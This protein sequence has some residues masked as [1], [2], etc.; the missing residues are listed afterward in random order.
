MLYFFFFFFFQAEDGI[1]DHCV[2]GVQTCALPI[3][4]AFSPAFRLVRS[5]LL[6]TPGSVPLKEMLIAPGAPFTMVTCSGSPSFKV[7]DCLSS[8]TCL[9]R[10]SGEV[11]IVG[12]AGGTAFPPAFPA[13]ILP[14]GV[15]RK[16]SGSTYQYH[17]PSTTFQVLP[18]GIFMGLSLKPGNI[19]YCSTIIVALARV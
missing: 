17:L 16:D 15:L 14:K 12:K 9:N 3:Y 5:N 7:T 4:T 19:T 2:T 6:S 8:F 1:R 11:G 18:V 10:K 13:V